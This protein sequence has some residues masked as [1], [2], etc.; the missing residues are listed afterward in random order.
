MVLVPKW[1]W[2]PFDTHPIWAMLIRY[3]FIKKYE[4]QNKF[5]CNCSM[6]EYKGRLLMNDHN[7]SV[8]DYLK[9]KVKHKVTEYI[10]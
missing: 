5:Q 3:K 8:E 4:A 9:A 2:F 7:M 10:M 6:L 1:I